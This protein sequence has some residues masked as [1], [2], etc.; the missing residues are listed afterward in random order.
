MRLKDAAVQALSQHPQT[1]HG[2][3][4]TIPDL[5]E[6]SRNRPGPTRT[7]PVKRSSSI[8]SSTPSG[9]GGSSMGGI[10]PP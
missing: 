8:R 10:D 1:G 9:I 6:I 5:E 2:P 3:I 7:G 4:R